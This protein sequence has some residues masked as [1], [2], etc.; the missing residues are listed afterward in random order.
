MGEAVVLNFQYRGFNLDVVVSDI[1]TL[2]LIY[3]V[4][5]YQDK[6]QKKKIQSQKTLG[7][8]MCIR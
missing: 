3:L 1:Y 7:L 2:N 8:I 4:I 5:E 6:A